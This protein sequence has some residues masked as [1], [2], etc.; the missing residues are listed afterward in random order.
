MYCLENA[1]DALRASNPWLM[2]SV[3]FE[4]LEGITDGSNR[5]FR[6]P[7]RPLDQ[8]SGMTV[9]DQ[10]GLEV[11]SGSYTVVSWDNGVVRFTQGVDEQYYADYNVTDAYYS[12]TRLKNLCED[13][14][15][16]M[17]ARWPQSWYLVESGGSTWISSTDPALTDPPIGALA[18]STS[19]VALHT[20]HLCCEYALASSRLRRASA[21]DVDY[22]EG[23]SGGVAVTT[24]HRADSLQ[25]LLDRLDKDIVAGLTVLEQEA[26]SDGYG[27]F[28][29]GAKSDS[30]EDVYEWWDDTGQ[31]TS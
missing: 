26:A 18:F 11:S 29:S 7:H 4:P 5:I 14:F 23:L 30:Y 28:V 24:H 12:A 6:T 20:Y 16:E 31:A 9:Y 15:R 22:R 19:H 10:T 2:E 17:M 8:T 27:G 21:E 13:G 3:D 25:G 1:R